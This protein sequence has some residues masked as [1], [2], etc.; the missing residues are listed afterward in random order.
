MALGMAGSDLE[1]VPVI[2][3][4]IKFFD[5]LF[6]RTSTGI[7]NWFS[8]WIGWGVEKIIKTFRSWVATAF[9]YG[10]IWAL[11]GGALA[12]PQVAFKIVSKISK[13]YFTPPA[14][15][16]GFIDSYIRQL[17]GEGIDTETIKKLGAAVGGRDII[18]RIGHTFLTPMLGLILPE[19][20]I[21]PQKGLEAAERYLGANIQFQLNAWL[22]HLIGDIVSL[23]KLKSLKDLPN[24]ISWSYGL[25]WLS[26][27]V[28]GTPFRKTISE[29]LEK[30]YNAQYPNEL[31]SVSDAMGAWIAGKWDY[32]R[33]KQELLWRGYDADRIKVLAFLAQKE[34]S[35]SDL[36]TL[37]NEGAI[38]EDDIDEEL[39][40]R[41]Y[42]E[43][44][45]YYL[46]VLIT[47]ARWLKWRD[48]VLDAA[49]DTFILGRLSESELRGYL[50]QCNFRSDEQDLVVDWAMLE[51]VK[52]CTPSDT[53]IRR[54]YKKGLIGLAEARR[55]LMDKGWSDRWA[56][57]ILS[58]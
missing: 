49:I 22:L 28:M 57:I 9:G 43:Y 30:F 10:A 8:G 1:K 46:K 2:G 38:T 36:K 4:L 51:K 6:K 20:D 24:A 53:D 18:Q 52:R 14:T 7:K 16:V 17:T 37:W 58:L 35:D 44:E 23:G 48:K 50:S 19:E 41:K 42:G 13:Y 39:R 25:G 15:W 55:M 56:D 29:P 27:L 32:A 47:K 3:D 33:L 40:L 31:L 45:R 12:H 11:R 26:W 21:T 34:L 54:A 5:N